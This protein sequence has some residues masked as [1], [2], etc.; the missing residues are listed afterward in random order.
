MLVYMLVRLYSPRSTRTQRTH[1]HIYR[2][3]SINRLI[4]I[5]VSHKQMVVHSFTIEILLF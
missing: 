1:T 2:Y 4:N 3:R 5:H